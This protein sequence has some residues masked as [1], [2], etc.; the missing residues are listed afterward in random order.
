MG[1]LNSF[2]ALFGGRE[3]RDE[4]GYWVY[5][6]C[7]RCGEPI[8]T[9]ID[10]RNEL[11]PRDEGGYFVRKTLVGSGRCFERVEVTLIFDENRRL[12]DREI[13]QGDFIPPEE[14]AEDRSS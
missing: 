10:L 3:G 5:V 14:F 6:R 13:A 4:S 11:S 9:R 7:R 1:L 8:R 2:K 12:V